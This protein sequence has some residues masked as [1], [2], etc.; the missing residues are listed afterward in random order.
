MRPQA[1][2]FI[3]FLMYIKLFHDSLGVTKRLIQVDGKILAYCIVW[4]VCSE[5]YFQK[6]I[7][8][9]DLTIRNTL[10]LGRGLLSKG[11][12]FWEGAYYQDYIVVVCLWCAELTARVSMSCMS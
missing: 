9:E 3:S 1:E 6:G 5:A 8:L 7:S 2:S 4:I 10:Y 11:A 12:Y